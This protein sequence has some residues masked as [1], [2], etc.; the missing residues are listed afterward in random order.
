ML[1]LC[2][3]RLPFSRAVVLHRNIFSTTTVLDVFSIQDKDDF[4]A[5]VVK[6]K[7]PVV[8]DFHATWC[9]PCKMLMPR[10]ET[11]I[12]TTNDA[13]DLAKVDIDD[14]SDIAIEYGVDVVPTVLSFKNGKVVEKFV[15]LQDD[16]KISK[17]VKAVQ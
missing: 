6:S 7:K 12:A 4:E 16:D 15:G 14:H 10:L 5:K 9:G 11:V 3:S 8:V 2:R 17:F 1:S 13:V